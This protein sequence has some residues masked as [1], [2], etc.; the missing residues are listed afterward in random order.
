MQQ[1]LAK[2]GMQGGNVPDNNMSGGM[3]LMN[4]M[5]GMRP[6]MPMQL[7]TPPNTGGIGQ[8]NPE[9]MQRL[10]Q[11]RMSQMRPQQPMY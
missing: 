2:R 1:I 9:L 10:I 5:S 3:R 11:G 6:Q 7:A 8:V 4:R